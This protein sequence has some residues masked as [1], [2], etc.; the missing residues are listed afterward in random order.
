MQEEKTTVVE[1]SL[2]RDEILERSRKE[3]A[4]DGD[5]R[6]QKLLQKG[7]G[8]ST[9]VGLV[10]LFTIYLVNVI[11]LKKNSYELVG[12]IMLMNGVNY[13]WQSIYSKKRRKVFL[14]IG[15]AYLIVSVAY[16]VLWVLTLCGF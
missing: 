8:I 6:E 11:V 1:Q 12:L 15:I 4:K 16:M 10:A 3:N 2:T 9:I 7:I 5:E 13:I 14:P